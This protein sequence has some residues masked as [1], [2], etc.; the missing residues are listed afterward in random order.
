MKRMIRTPQTT[1]VVITLA[2]CHGFVTPPHSIARMKHIVAAMM[3]RF[4]MKSICR[5]FSRRLAFTGFAAVGV[6]KRVRM[7]KA[8]GIPIGKLM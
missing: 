2:E 4:P 5:N 3:I 6:L 8:E 7:I 1:S